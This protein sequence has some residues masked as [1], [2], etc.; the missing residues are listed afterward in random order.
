MSIH[1]RL[2]QKKLELYEKHRLDECMS[3]EEVADEIL[4]LRSNQFQLQLLNDFKVQ[5]LL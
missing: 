4:S 5:L 1:E 3:D 2:E